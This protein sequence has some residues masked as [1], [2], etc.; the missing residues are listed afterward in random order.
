M[1]P[2]LGTLLL[3]LLLLV[4]AAFVGVTS[5][6]L[7]PIV[8]SHFASGGTVNGYMP[9]GVYTVLLL[10][11]IVGVPLLLALLPAA[12]AGSGGKNL[13][14]PNRDFW[15]APQRRERTLA[16]I[17]VHGLWFA[18]AVAIFMAYVHWLVLQ[19]NELRPPHLSVIGLTSGLMVFLLILVVWLV[20]L[21]AHFRR[22]D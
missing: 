8:A 18:A 1:N 19:A 9:R 15:L 22:H 20:V 16:F 21:V 5:S 4:L 6:T 2:R 3:L 17:R 13:N 10:T 7:P 14:I 11:L 12:V